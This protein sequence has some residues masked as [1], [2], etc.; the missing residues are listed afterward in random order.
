LTLGIIGGL[1]PLVGAH[2][3]SLLF[4]MTDAVADA[5]YPDLLLSSLSSTPDRTAYLLDA[6]APDPTPALLRAARS[7]SDGGADLLLLLCHTA[8]AFLPDLRARVSVPILDLVSLGVSAAAEAG[9][10]RLGVLCSE[11]TVRARLYDAAAA[12]FGIQVLYPPPSVRRD[13]HAFIYHR[14]KSGSAGGEGALLAAA[15]SLA[16]GGAEGILLGCTELSLPAATGAVSLPLPC[17]DPL[18]LLAFRAMVLC[19]K[20]IKEAYPYDAAWRPAL[21]P[22][23]RPIARKP[24]FG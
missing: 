3:L 13:L 4:E 18:Y 24:S 2:F 23:S 6:R 5:D 20:K 7:L 1:G 15:L 8:H 14:L 22:L 9:V 16:D 11:G 19:G 12:F 17:L 21:V 10:R